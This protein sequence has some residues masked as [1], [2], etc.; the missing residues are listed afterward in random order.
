MNE[1]GRYHLKRFPRKIAAHRLIIYNFLVTS[2]NKLCVFISFIQIIL[3][4]ATRIKSNHIEMKNIKKKLDF[5]FFSF[6]LFKCGHIEVTE[7]D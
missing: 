5:N 6:F 2:L 4:F 1:N 7:I 3:S